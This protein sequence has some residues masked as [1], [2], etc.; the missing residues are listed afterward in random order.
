MIK[1]LTSTT[2]TEIYTII[3][4]LGAKYKT[5]IPSD[6]YNF[7]CKKKSDNIVIKNNNFSYE[8]IA[9]IA[10]LHYKYWT[11]SNEEKEK[12]EELFIKNEQKLKQNVNVPEIQPL[13]KE[14]NKELLSK[15]KSDA[16]KDI[17]FYEETIIKKIFN[18][19]K[20]FIKSFLKKEK[21]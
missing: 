12:L 21:K 14:K 10:T 7:I 8:A 19:I 16:N 9:F 20:N 5:R 6:I 18:K 2:Y 13:F 17:I 4:K 15:Y 1:E 11:N 3:E